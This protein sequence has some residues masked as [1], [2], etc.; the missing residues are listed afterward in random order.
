MFSI[1]AAARGEFAFR[2]PGEQRGDQRNAEHTEE[3]GCPKPSHPFIVQPV[4]VGAG[5][6][7]VLAGKMIQRRWHGRCSNQAMQHQHW[8]PTY[9]CS[10]LVSLQYVDA[11]GRQKRTTAN[12]EEIGPNCASLLV[13]ARIP[14]GARTTIET[15]G[16]R[17]QGYARGAVHEEPLGWFVDVKLSPDSSWSRRRYTPEHLLNAFRT[18]CRRTPPR[19]NTFLGPSGC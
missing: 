10:E 6:E 3:Q 12:L 7:T 2:L 5:A 13:E 15:Q 16:Q 18:P 19:V 1:A 11:A 4:P 17:L 14:R 8:A 9:L